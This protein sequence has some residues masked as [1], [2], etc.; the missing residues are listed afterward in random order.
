M[1]DPT[2]AEIRLQIGYAVDALEELRQFAESDANNLLGIEAEL[3]ASVKGDYSA[4]ILG[5]FS[6]FRARVSEALARNTTRAILDAHLF[7]Y[8]KLIGSPERDAASIFRDLYDYFVENSYTVE[9]RNFTFGTPSAGASN[10]GNGTL[11]RLNVDKNG[12]DIDTQTA[13]AKTVTCRFD[14]HSGRPEHAEQFEIR[15]AER[16]RDFLSLKGGTGQP[17]SR[18]VGRLIALTCR[19]ST[20]FI[21]N[22]SFTNGTDDPTSSTDITGWTIDDYTKVQLQST[23]YYRDS[24]GEATPKSLR[25]DDNAYVQ[26]N[27]NVAGGRVRT[28]GIGGFGQ[29]YQPIYV[30]VAY[31]S[32]VGSGDGTLTLTIGSKTASVSVSGK[33]GWQVLRIAVGTSNWYENWIQ[34]NPLI[35]IQLASRTTGYVLVDDVVIAPFQFFDGGWYALV[36]GST[37]FLVND[38]FTFTDSAAET[39]I[40]QKWFVRAGYG[41]LPSAVAGAADWGD[42]PPTPTPTPSP[43]PTVTPTPTPT[44]TPRTPS[45]TPTPATPTPTP[46]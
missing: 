32:S 23:Q 15:G 3:R 16:F 42:P 38:S 37:P 24:E 36:G 18:P 41:Y 34:E 20:Q 26:Q 2:E 30:Q 45:P 43:T 5:G 39:G 14:E 19:D 11:L 33:S 40:L 1:A 31:N 12:Y 13:D 29:Y 46:T 17:G 22:P 10:D 35:K 4:E 21:R 9:E 28:S 7:S 25:L 27:L 6:A 44:P 8:G